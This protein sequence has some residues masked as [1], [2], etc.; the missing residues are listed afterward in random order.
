MPISAAVQARKGCSGRVKPSLALPA[1]PERVFREGETLP[2]PPPQ[3]RKGCSGRVI[4]LP[5]L[6]PGGVWGDTASLARWGLRKHRL[7]R[8]VGFEEALPRSV[9]FGEAS[10][11]LKSRTPT[12]CYNSPTH[13]SLGVRPVSYRVAKARGFT[14]ARH[15]PWRMPPSSTAGLQRPCRSEPWQRLE[16]ICSEHTT[17][18]ILPSGRF[19]ARTPNA[20]FLN[21]LEPGPPTWRR[22]CAFR[23]AG[24]VSRKNKCTMK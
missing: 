21:A 11:S 19:P 9:G 22:T 13:I 14:L 3:A 5:G 15:P 8:P 10:P 7:A 17:L 24:T 20:Q 6:L 16:T 18:N 23:A 2:G 1:S 4:T 12:V